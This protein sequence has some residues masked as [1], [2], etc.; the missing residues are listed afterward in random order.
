MLPIQD[1]RELLGPTSEITDDEI[2]ALRDWLYELTNLA[3]EVSGL[4]RDTDRP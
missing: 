3:I 1:C 2:A 4:M